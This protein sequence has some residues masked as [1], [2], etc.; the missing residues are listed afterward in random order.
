VVDWQ[1]P[2]ALYGTIAKVYGYIQRLPDANTANNSLVFIRATS[3]NSVLVP[4]NSSFAVDTFGREAWINVFWIGTNNAGYEPD[5][6]L[7][8]AQAAVSFLR[9]PAKRFVVM[10]VLNNSA[11]TIGTDVYLKITNLNEQLKA[12]YPENFIDIRRY[13]I[14]QY[15]PSSAQ[16]L[17]DVANDVVPSSLRSDTIHLNTK[18]YGL[19]AQQV[20][21]FIGSHGW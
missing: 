6:V 1:G 14:S 7:S 11:S 18:G 9:K 4:D 15:D 17:A 13:L 10:S 20:A 8:D 3:G 2:S 19:V 12:T 21:A 5:R 16:D